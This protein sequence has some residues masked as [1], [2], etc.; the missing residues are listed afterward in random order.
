M[1]FRSYLATGAGV[2]GESPSDSR[3]A[4]GHELPAPDRTNLRYLAT[5]L[6][7]VPQQPVLQ[8][9]FPCVMPGASNSDTLLELC[10]PFAPRFCFR[11]LGDCPDRDFD[12]QTVVLEFGSRTRKMGPGRQWPPIESGASC[13]GDFAIGFGALPGSV[14][15][16]KK[17]VFQRIDM[18]MLRCASRQ[19]DEE[20]IASRILFYLE[21]GGKEQF[22][23]GAKPVFQVRV[24]RPFAL[25]GQFIGA[26]THPGDQMVELLPSALANSLF[27]SG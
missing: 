27:G 26:M 12:F 14:A 25:L 10:D 9:T 7:P 18:E 3:P 22:R 5:P 24:I 23:L 11:Q 8:S 13:L 6:P 17:A 1:G 4:Y 16:E 2:A 15:C 19:G 21:L 20:L